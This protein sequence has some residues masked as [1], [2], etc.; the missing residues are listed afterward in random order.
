MFSVVNTPY[1][2]AEAVLGSLLHSMLAWM[3]R[4]QLLQLGQ[5]YAVASELL[6]LAAIIVTAAAAAAAAPPDAPVGHEGGSDH[7]P[8][9]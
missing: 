7:G 5:L 3:M 1:T 6:V 8:P 4:L 9:L 2:A